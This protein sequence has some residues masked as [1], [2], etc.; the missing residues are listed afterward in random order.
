MTRRRVPGEGDMLAAHMGARKEPRESEIGL[1]PALGEPGPRRRFTPA[2]RGTIGVMAAVLLLAVLLVVILYE[3]DGPSIVEKAAAALAGSEKAVLHLQIAAVQDDG[4]G[5]PERWE[6]EAWLATAAP[7]AYRLVEEP[8]D[9]P[10]IERAGDGRGLVQLYDPR[11]GT[12]HQ[13]TDAASTEAMDPADVNLRSIRAF[14]QQALEL[15]RSGRAEEA[16]HVSI[17]GRDAIQIVGPDAGGGGRPLVYTVDAETGAP[18][19]W[20]ATG[21]GGRVTLRF[22][23]YE[24]FPATP[25]NL[26]LLDLRAQHPGAR[27]ETDP[28]RYRET[29]ARLCPQG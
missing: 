16:G 17:D 11:T 21:D 2:R 10:V 23:A 4:D 18:V 6:I 3:S 25:G 28:V 5:T 20:Q 7:G 24:E 26:T 1:A 29:R 13:G 19:E 27:V 22:V 12:I 15:L 8:P 9:R 14:E